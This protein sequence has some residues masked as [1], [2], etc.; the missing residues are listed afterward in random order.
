MEPKRIVHEMKIR[1]ITQK[2]L[3]AD[4]GVR[5]QAVSM[6]VCGKKNICRIRQAVADAI[7][8]PVEA[9]FP[10]GKSNQERT[11]NNQKNTRRQNSCTEAAA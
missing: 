3:A 6:V 9:V 1:G 10:F 4:L 5:P 8:R 7:G 11:K 2:A